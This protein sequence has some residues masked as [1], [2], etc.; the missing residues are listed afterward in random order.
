MGKCVP[1]EQRFLNSGAVYF[2]NGVDGEQVRVE[3]IPDSITRF[4]ASYQAGG[5]TVTVETILGSQFHEG[6]AYRLNDVQ[7][8]ASRDYD[9]QAKHGEGCLIVDLSSRST[10]YIAHSSGRFSTYTR[11]LVKDESWHSKPLS[12]RDA[13]VMYCFSMTQA[14]V[15]SI[16]RGRYIV[17]PLYPIIDA[18]GRRHEPERMRNRLRHAMAAK[19]TGWAVP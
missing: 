11:T 17:I 1:F 15:T 8:Y 7:V 10:G 5:E 4:G 16:K 13:A 19:Y 3:P 12:P 18:Q 14:G 9:H 6:C 2:A